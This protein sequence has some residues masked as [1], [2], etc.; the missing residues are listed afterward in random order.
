MCAL[1]GISQTYWLSNGSLNNGSFG[2]NLGTFN[3][4]PINIYTNSTQRMRINGAA[5]GYGVNTSGFIGIGT[6]NPAAPLHIVGNQQQASVGWRRGLTLS[7][8]AALVWDG[9]GGDGFLMAHPSSSPTGNFYAGVLNNLNVSSPV[10]Y[11]Y[12]VY[13]N[14]LFGGNPQASAQF[15]KNVLVYEQGS[16]R[17]LG[18]NVQSPNHAAE[19]YE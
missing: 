1:N 19:L 5:S 15:F 18:V 16:E 3:N 7:N 6:N 2:N 17:Y 10:N 11:A 4:Y 13:V 12:T 9:S 8:S 14:Q